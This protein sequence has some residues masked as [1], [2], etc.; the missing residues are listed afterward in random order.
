MLH[1]L[2]ELALASLALPLLCGP[3]R[4]FSPSLFGVEKSSLSLALKWHGLAESTAKQQDD[5]DDEQDGSDAEAT[6][7]TQPRP[8]I[9][10]AAEAEQYEYDEKNK[11]CSLRVH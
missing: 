3:T 9:P 10:A 1:A 6:V 2:R 4:Q 5:K 11:H 7:I 8:G